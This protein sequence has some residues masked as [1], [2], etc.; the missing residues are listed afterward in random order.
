MGQN[1]NAQFR[2]VSSRMKETLPAGDGFMS[3]RSV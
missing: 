3:I 2:N 1:A